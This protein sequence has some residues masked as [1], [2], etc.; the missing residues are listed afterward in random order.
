MDGATA[1]LQAASRYC[2]TSKSNAR[3]FEREPCLRI[4]RSEDQGGDSGRREASGSRGRP[5]SRIFSILGRLAIRPRLLSRSASSF[6]TPAASGPWDIPGSCISS[7]CQLWTGKL[8][9]Y[10]RI[11]DAP[12]DCKACQEETAWRAYRRLLGGCTVIQELPM[13]SVRISSNDGS[14]A[15]GRLAGGLIVE[16][17][18]SAGDVYRV[19]YHCK[20]IE[21]SIRS[22]LR[23]RHRGGCDIEQRGS[24]DVGRGPPVRHHHDG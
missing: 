13:G 6:P 18:L 23:C 15:A 9:S 22:S 3:D 19:G 7:S 14:V 24:N 8:G 17:E 12:D 5:S 16:R 21:P 2:H 4:A 1:R 10:H 20:R 11:G